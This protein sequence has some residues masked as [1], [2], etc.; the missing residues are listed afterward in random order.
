[1]GG[2]PCLLIV[3]V[4]Y[5]LGAQLAEELWD[6]NACGGVHGAE[7]SVGTGLW[8]PWAARA[9]C[10]PLAMPVIRTMRKGKAVHSSKA[11][12]KA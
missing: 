2:V 1:M 6:A 10:E 4:G 9:S 11:P 12:M 5:I 7:R 3:L 8:M